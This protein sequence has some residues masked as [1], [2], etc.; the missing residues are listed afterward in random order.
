[1]PDLRTKVE[2]DRGLLKRLEMAIPGFRGYR[3]RE[4]L[5]VADS[6]L[7]KQLADALRNVGTKIS[8]CRDGLVKNM[9]LDLLNDVKVLVNT[10][11]MTENKVRH[12][13]Q[14]YTGISPDYRIGTDE[15]NRMYEWDISLLS[16]IDGLSKKV[17]IL[18]KN[19]LA[20]KTGVGQNL[21]VIK[22]DIRKFNATFDTRR[23][24]FAGLTVGK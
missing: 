5:R 21:R 17:D 20:G 15:L 19:I 13:E 12:A 2:Q 6:L 23:E 1:M 9:E 8:D 16:K 18:Y 7:R 11:Q 22:E 4:D 3:K 14:G 10:I 24:A